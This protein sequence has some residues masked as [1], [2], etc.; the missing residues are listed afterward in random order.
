MRE[1]F[2]NRNFRRLF[3]SNL[4]AGFGQ[5]MTMIG[6]SWYLVEMTG[7]A[8][9]LGSTMLISS[10]LVFLIGPF[11]GAVIDRFSRK[12]IL[13]IEQL[14]GF[15]VLAVLTAWGFWGTYQEWMMVL[16]YLTT[17]FMLQIHYPTQS[18]LVQETFDQ[19]QYNAINSLLEIQNQTALVS[20]GALAGILLVKFGLQIVLLL[21]ALT[22]LLAFVLLSGMDYVFT[23]KQPAT[24]NIRISWRQQFNQGWIFIRERRGFMIFGVSA[25]VPFIAVT[26]VNL[27]NPIFVRQTLKEDVHIYS[28]AEVSYSIGAVL[29]GVCIAWISRKFGAFSSM[30]FHFMLMA[31]V[32]ALTVVLPTGWIF[33]LLSAFLG[34]CNV[35][36]RLIRQNVYM[37]LL[38]NHFMGRVLSSLNSV[39]TLMRLLLLALFTTIIDST[40]AEVGFLVLAGLLVVSGAGIMVS[41]R[42]L[43][44]Q[45]PSDDEV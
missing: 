34:W 19:K 9:L 11:T 37:Q 7:M 8:R 22:Y 21:N 29:A 20:A 2:G 24:K 39:G 5:G 14:G 16:I 13:Q 36:T 44:E 26:L 33:V 1:V 38:P 40:G 35:S 45:V 4:F 41:M 31:L 28:L 10:I 12:A 42:M 32:L 17:T 6:I 25:L 3:F 23:V 27:L 30:V 43:M 18:A 15:I